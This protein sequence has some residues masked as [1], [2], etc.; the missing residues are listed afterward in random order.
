MA[1]PSKL[2]LNAIFKPEPEGGFTVVVPALPGCVTYGKTL[3]EA[4][5]MAVDAVAGYLVSL[6][7]HGDPLPSDEDSFISI[8]QV[9][10]ESLSNA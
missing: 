9:S 4:K 10:A 7:K 1:K 3:K 2:Q 8:I 5:A 6:K